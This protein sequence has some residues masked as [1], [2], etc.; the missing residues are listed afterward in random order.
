M[1]LAR[2]GRWP[3]LY[4]GWILVLALALTE[5]TSYG[6]LYYAF[7]VFV[8]PME[9]E[10]GWSRA[11]LTG[12]F[13][14]ALLVSGLAGLLVGRWLDRHGPRLLMTVG[15]IAAS[16]L[17]LAW[18][19]VADLASFYLVWVLIG[20]AMAAVLYEPAFWVVATWFHRQRGR[21]LTV[22]TFVAG[23]ASVVYVPLAAWLVDA[24]G[25]RAALATL[26]GLLA[27]GTVPLHALVLRRRPEDLGLAPDGTP[28]PALA[29]GGPA[30]SDR[31]ATPRQALRS[32]AFWWL[33]AAFVLNMLGAAA[34]TVH[35]LPYL[36]DRGF[37]TG[38]AA[39]AV[40]L[41]GALALPGRLIF[42]PL[43]DRL[44]RGLVTTAL[45][46]LQ[47]VALVVLLVVPTTAGVIGFVALFGAGF[48]AITPARAALVADFF[49]RSHYG[50][51]SALLALFVTTARALGPVGAGLGYDLARSY[52]AVF[53]L[54]A[55]ASALAGLAVLRADAA[56]RR[57][58]A[59]RPY[60]TT[61]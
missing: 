25:W 38:F 16:L 3:R 15:S 53:W 14:L 13:S 19:S 36:V 41:I 12:A 1:P 43:G 60:G 6:V 20:L 35:L 34:I 8:R 2:P 29:A 30:G 21:A 40:G 26:A 45:F 4:F 33:V 52:D 51:I 24:Q 31:A 57:G 49:G 10:L 37:E 47:A 59:D 55:L 27:V 28:A 58:A 17:V 46:L 11:A 50:S 44:S 23:F 61:S 7:T 32:A 48:G 9:Q 42:T 22:L 56:A 39:A 18:A 5:T 54:L